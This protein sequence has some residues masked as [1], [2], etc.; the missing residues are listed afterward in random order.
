MRY[1]RRT[2]ALAA[3]AGIV[4]GSAVALAGPARADGTA[5]CGGNQVCLYYDSGQNGAHIGFFWNVSDYDNDA[6]NNGAYWTFPDDGDGAGQPV[7]NNVASARNYDAA[8]RVRIYY[9]ENYNASGAAPYQDLS[10]GNFGNLSKAMT[11]NNASH[12]WFC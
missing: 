3:T 4:A 12:K 2:A 11:D 6:E 7:K 5:A 9:N 8:C 10:P 1:L